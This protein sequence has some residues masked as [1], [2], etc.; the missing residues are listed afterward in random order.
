MKRVLMERDGMSE[1]EAETFVSNLQDDINKAV[2]ENASLCD[3]EDILLNEAG[4]EPDYLEEF[5]FG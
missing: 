4:L 1:S 3:I 2:D 5:L